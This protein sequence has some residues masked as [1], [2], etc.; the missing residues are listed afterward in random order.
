MC[1]IA[2]I[3]GGAPDPGVLKAMADT[4]VNRGPDGEGI[5]SD[6]R[7]GLAFRRLAIIDL[8]ERSNQPLHLELAAPRLQRRDL[9]LPRAARGAR[10]ARAPLRDRGRRRGAAARLAPV[11]RGCARAPQR[12]VRVR[13]LGRSRRRRLTL[14]SRPVRR[15]AALLRATQGG[16]LA[17]RLRDQGAAA[18]PARCAPRPTS[19]RWPRFLARGV[20]PA[21]GRSFF[22]GV[23]RLPAAHLLRCRA[24]AGRD[25]ALLVAARRSTCR[26]DDARGRRRA[27]R[28]AARLDPAAPAQRR[29]GRHV[30][31]RRPRLVGGRRRSRPSWRATTRRHAFTARFPGFER[32]EWALRAQSSPRRRASSSTTRSSRR[33]DELLADLRLLVR[34]HEEPVAL[35]EHLRAVARDRAAREAAGVTVLLDG[36]GGDELLAG[37]PAPAGAPRALAAAR[38]SAARSVRARPLADRAASCCRSATSRLPAARRARLPAAGGDARTR[39]AR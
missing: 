11:G 30:A 23:E 14:A 19:R 8:H 3:A 20:M 16:R 4:M 29:A 5:W 12:D 37:Y 7:A 18:R 33:A 32:D 22:A 24:R 1:G 10:G 21:L 38:A 36:Q 17:V 25:R 15:E 27:A 35:V 6:E 2:G 28:A 13:G 39:P 9:Q 26:R 31:Q 34:D